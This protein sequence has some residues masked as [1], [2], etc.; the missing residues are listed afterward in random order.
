MLKE[1]AGEMEEDTQS[2]F[3]LKPQRDN[4]AGC[5]W[6]SGQRVQHSQRVCVCV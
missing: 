3:W 1:A 6:E 5:E 4:N 2:V